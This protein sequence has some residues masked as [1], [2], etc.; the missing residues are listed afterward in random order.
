MTK[1]QKLKEIESEIEGYNPKKVIAKGMRKLGELGFEF[2]G[3][4]CGGGGEDFGLIKCNIGEPG[5]DDY[6]YVN[7]CDIGRRVVVSVSNNEECLFEGNV[8]QV[9]LFVKKRDK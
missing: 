4:G 7:F 1:K 9:L 5:E 3:H 8:G 2:S 6:L